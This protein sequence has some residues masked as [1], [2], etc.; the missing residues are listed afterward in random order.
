MYEFVRTS[1][2]YRWSIYR[3]SGKCRW[4]I[5]RTS[6]KRRGTLWFVRKSGT[7]FTHSDNSWLRYATLNLKALFNGLMLKRCNSIS[8][9][10][11]LSLYLLYWQMIHPYSSSLS[12]RPAEQGSTYKKNCTC[13]NSKIQHS[14]QNHIWFEENFVQIINIIFVTLKLLVQCLP[15]FGFHALWV[16]IRCLLGFLQLF[17]SLLIRS[18]KC[19]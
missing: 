6:R 1:S 3:T 7:E 9:A 14:I 8:N 2:K 11:E 18:W 12:W 15:S 19:V 16:E 4:S 5:Y 13:P 17:T 10:L